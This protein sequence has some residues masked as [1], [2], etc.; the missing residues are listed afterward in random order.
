VNIEKQIFGSPSAIKGRTFACT[1]EL[2]RREKKLAPPKQYPNPIV[3]A[4]GWQRRLDTGEAASRA[5]LARK[6]GVSRAH[7]TQV[8]RLLN[9]APQVKATILALGDPI[10]GKF[11]GLHTLR[12]LCNLSAREQQRK[13]KEILSL[14]RPA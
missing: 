9:M 4:Q 2:P 13:L 5:D 10:Q 3:L 8:L 12:P 7:V 14:T 11:I 6:L 1:F